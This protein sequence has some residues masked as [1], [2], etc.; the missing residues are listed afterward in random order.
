MFAGIMV[1]LDW[2]QVAVV[3]AILAGRAAH[4]CGDD[5]DKSGES[6]QSERHGRF[7]SVRVYLG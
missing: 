2:L 5:N 7:L 3:V 1:S 6:D 4:E